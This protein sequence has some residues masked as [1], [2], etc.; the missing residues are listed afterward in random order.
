MPQTVRITITPDLA[1]ALQTLRSSTMGTLNTTEL[2]KLAVGSFARMKKAD[3]NAKELDALSATSFYEWAKGD[4]VTNQ[5]MLAQP[6]KLQPFVPKPYV[7][8]S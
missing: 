1:E 8:T 4:K 2:I 5:E 7:R 3:M 6:E